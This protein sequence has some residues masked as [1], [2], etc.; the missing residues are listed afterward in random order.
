MRRE[1]GIPINIDTTPSFIRPSIFEVNL[2][3]LF[4]RSI[5]LFDEKRKEWYG[6]S[7]VEAEQSL[8]CAD[9]MREA[10]SLLNG[11]DISFVRG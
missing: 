4:L 8:V 11:T 3:K 9:Y 5:K 7:E 2:P 6:K 10:R 1:K